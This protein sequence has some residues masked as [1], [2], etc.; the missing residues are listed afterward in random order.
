MHIRGEFEK[1]DIDRILG[2]G[3]PKK[4]IQGKRIKWADVETGSFKKLSKAEYQS[5]I[6]KG[7]AANERL[8]DR[9]EKGNIINNEMMN[10][11]VEGHTDYRDAPRIDL[12]RL[13]SEFLNRAYEAAKQGREIHKGDQE[14]QL[15]A[16]PTHTNV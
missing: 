15:N 12:S 8:A 1:Q 5:R 13:D 6:V 16:G 4:I 7:E 14:L 9:D 11:K 3:L 10:V 2:A